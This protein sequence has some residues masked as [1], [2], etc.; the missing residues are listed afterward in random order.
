MGRLTSGCIS[1]EQ[2]I[3][4]W[5]C[6]FTAPAQV[7]F[8]YTGRKCSS[9]GGR[10]KDFILDW[11]DALPEVEYEASQQHAS[12]ADLAIALGTSL[13]IIPACNIPLR[14]VKT[15]PPRCTRLPMV[16]HVDH[17]Y[18]KETILLGCL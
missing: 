8:R 6:S 5:R 16:S 18:V 2:G 15:G 1:N 3:G 17:A 10:L 7:G 11:E 13:Q 9:C 14:T 4:S 12:R